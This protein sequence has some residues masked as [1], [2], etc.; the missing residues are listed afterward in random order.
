MKGCTIPNVYL[1]ILLCIHHILICIQ[2]IHLYTKIHLYTLYTKV[3][4]LTFDFVVIKVPDE[5]QV[6]FK[7]SSKMTREK[8]R[9]E[10]KH[11][12]ILQQIL[13]FWQR[14]V[15]FLLESKEHRVL[16]SSQV[17]LVIGE[18]KASNSLHP[19]NLR[20]CHIQTMKYSDLC[21]STSVPAQSLSDDVILIRSWNIYVWILFIT[22]I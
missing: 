5:G 12:S 13:I 22:P 15:P 9:E 10:K 1:C 16:H 2:C 6:P 7:H 19:L 4:M 8:D 14:E 18:R 17:E 11:S 3:H 21:I 20:M